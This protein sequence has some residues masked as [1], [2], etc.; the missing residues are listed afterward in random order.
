MKL[1]IK[2]FHNVFVQST[3]DMQQNLNFYD[4]P[5]L[6]NLNLN[7]AVWIYVLCYMN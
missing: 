5:I 6:T 7:K 4:Y 1:L 3:H 2:Y